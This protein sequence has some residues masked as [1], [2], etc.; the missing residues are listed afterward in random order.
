MNE[1]EKR[2]SQELRI[3]A[4]QM[5]DAEQHLVI[6]TFQKIVFDQE[7]K[8]VNLQVEACLRAND[9]KE[10]QNQVKDLK[11]IIEVLEDFLND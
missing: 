8:L 7:V 1:Q 5:H 11:E 4:L 10:L 3:S 2:F 6:E 9:Y